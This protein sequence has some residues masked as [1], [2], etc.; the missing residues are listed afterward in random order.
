VRAFAFAAA[1]G[2]ALPA[3][4]PSSPGVPQPASARI[5]QPTPSAPEPTGAVAAA[6]QVPNVDATNDTAAA[7]LPAIPA[8]PSTLRG[9]RWPIAHPRITLPFG[10]WR[11]GSRIVDG[12]PFHDGVD[13]ATFCG[14]RVVAA[15][16]GVVLAAGRHY[17][18]QMGWVGNLKP[19]FDRLEA[20]SLWTTLPIVV[21]VDD[22]N[23]Y[24]SLYAHFGKIVVKRGDEVHA[25][26][27]LGYEGRTGHA[28]GCHLHYGLFS[29]DDPDRFA[30]DQAVAQHMKLPLW[31]V[32]RIDPLLVL[33]ARPTPTAR[34]SASP[35]PSP[36]TPGDGGAD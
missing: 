16:D 12:K 14:D 4:A 25:G 34:P 29:P 9:Y 22:G 13:L 10:P 27:L 2:L 23:G 6:E 28:S 21:V 5:V 3:L 32:A 26:Q 30:I 7:S 24:R 35:T 36:V 11:G 19:Y 33:P 20:K 31:E 18:S 8:D 17:D 1:A 15:H